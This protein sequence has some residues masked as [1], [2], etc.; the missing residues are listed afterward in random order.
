MKMLQFAPRRNPRCLMVCFTTALQLCS[1]RYL[2]ESII[3]IPSYISSPCA[4]SAAFPTQ[5]HV[6][7]MSHSLNNKC[8]MFPPSY[9][10]TSSLSTNQFM[11][12]CDQYLSA[13]VWP[14]D[15]AARHHKCH[16]GRASPTWQERHA[17]HGVPGQGGVVPVVTRNNTST[18]DVDKLWGWPL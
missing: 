8:V 2:L 14:D 15:C 5:G 9:L 11:E 6:A 17:D 10:I 16:S 12:H 18:L 13:R 1:L 3:I 4:S 7:S